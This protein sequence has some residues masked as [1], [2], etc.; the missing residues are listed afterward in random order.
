M[1]FSPKSPV[2]Y[3]VSRFILEKAIGDKV[4]LLRERFRVKPGM[5]SR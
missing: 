3:H 4:K 2:W 1:I 5:T